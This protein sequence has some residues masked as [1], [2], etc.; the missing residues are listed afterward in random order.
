MS[1]EPN[2]DQRPLDLTGWRASGKEFED[3]LD[4][5]FA[6]LASGLYAKHGRGMLVVQL[7]DDNSWARAGSY[8]P[9]DD[10]DDA[11]EGHHAALELIRLYDPQTQAVLGYSNEAGDRILDA[12][13]IAIRNVQSASESATTRPARA[14]T[15]R[16]A[17]KG[18]V[19]RPAPAS[20][21]MIECVRAEYCQQRVEKTKAGPKWIA[22]VPGG[23]AAIYGHQAADVA[24]GALWFCSWGC[25]K[26]F[27][28]ALTQQQAAAQR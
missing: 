14:G 25:L 9:A 12:K 11:N 23:A 13:V 22:V 17:A 6:N 18:T 15:A 3:L 10:L 19:D 20:R 21:P 1:K 26:D 28:L 16:S 2:H 24:N 8:L 5:N 7:A 27:A 4:Q